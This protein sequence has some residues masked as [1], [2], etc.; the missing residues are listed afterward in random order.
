MVLINTIYETSENKGNSHVSCIKYRNLKNIAHYHSDYELIYI[1]EGAVKV[2]VGE[3]SIILSESQCVFVNS[4]EIHCIESDENAKTTV[5][6][7]DEKYFSRLFGSKRLS[8]SVISAEDLTKNALAQISEELSLAEE[9]SDAMADS[10]TVQLF[11]KLLRCGKTEM[12]ECKKTIENKNHRLYS[13]ICEKISR[14]Y[15]SVT[16]EEMAEHVHFSG[17][18]F[19]NV[20]ADLF[21]MSFTQYVNVIKIASAIDLLRDGNMSVTEISSACGFNTI[22]NFNRV[23]KKF[24]GYS[25]SRLPSDYIFLY[26]LENGRGLNPTL[27]CTEILQS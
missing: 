9:N 19:S 22:R 12:A 1:D 17:P 15:A 25:P 4:N 23:F 11:V 18:Y 26:S 6:K 2:T 13:A 20:F 7:A 24:T 21:G 5:L 10:L 3:N 14:E 16:F 27:N 8:S